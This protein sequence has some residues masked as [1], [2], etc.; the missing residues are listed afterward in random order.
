MRYFL[1]A[2]MAGSGIMTILFGCGRLWNI[3]SF[4]YYV[5]IQ[6]SFSLFWFTLCIVSS[7]SHLGE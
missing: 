1:T 2:G 5:A 3:H 4:A 7:L 6:V